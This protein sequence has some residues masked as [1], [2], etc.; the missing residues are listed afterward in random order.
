MDTT[1]IVAYMNGAV[2]DGIEAVGAALLVL[3]AL[4]LGF[5]W[6]KAMFF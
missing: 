2:T 6:L 3:A 5:K 4:A 1:A